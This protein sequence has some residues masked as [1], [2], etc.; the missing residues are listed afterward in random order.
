MGG[1]DPESM[2]C[3]TG[4]AM[5]T[6]NVG[7]KGTG[8]NILRKENNIQ[9]TCDVGAFPSMLPGYQDAGSPDV[10]KKFETA[11]GRK[12]PSSPGLDLPGM[13]DAVGESNLHGMLVMEENPF[14]YSPCDGMTELRSVL[15][16]LDFLVLLGSTLTDLA[17]FADVVLPAECCAEKT[18]TYTSME[19]R[20]QL[21]RK[22]ISPPEG[23]MSGFRIIGELSSRMGYSMDYSS[24]ADIMDEI[25]SLVPLYGGISHAR[26]GKKGLQWPCPSPDHP[27]TPYLYGESF[28]SG[29]ARFPS[30]N[31]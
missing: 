6:G 18:G 20:V 31:G 23:V 4:L 21:V 25:A 3:L 7:K 1:A 26:L 14:L 19:R 16:R 2:R 13:I 30:L 5:M 10:R 12:L 11:W 27:G 17:D 28:P 9:G 8:V 15:S 22:I 29:K 24:T